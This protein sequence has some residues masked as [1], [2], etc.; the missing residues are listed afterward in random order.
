M[1]GT[2]PLLAGPLSLR[3]LHAHYTLQT[4][5]APKQCRTNPRA[6][7]ATPAAAHGAPTALLFVPRPP[8]RAAPFCNPCS[9]CPH[10]RSTSQP[11]AAAAAS[12]WCRPCGSATSPP[13]GSIWR[14]RRR[15]SRR[16][17]GCGGSAGRSA[18]CR[19]RRA[20]GRRCLRSRRPS[21]RPWRRPR[22]PRTCRCS[23]PSRTTCTSRCATAGAA[24][25]RGSRSPHR[26]AA[27]GGPQ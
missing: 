6:G 3:T 11:R 23:S 19:A 18:A 9:K 4:L 27:R 8:M 20:A 1:D 10:R 13:S 14:R 15:P 24:T 26:A 12:P 16:R 22:R 7:A 2:Q 17:A 21:R 5:L 25:W